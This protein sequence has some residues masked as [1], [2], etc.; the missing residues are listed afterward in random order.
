MENVVELKT[1][2]TQLGD[3][4]YSYI[5]GDVWMLGK[6]VAS[7]LEYQ[8]TDYA[9]RTHV[10][11]DNLLTRGIIG[12]TNDTRIKYAKFI[13]E[14]GF[15][16]LSMKSKKPNAVQLQ[17]WIANEVLPSLR[18]EG[19]Y[20]MNGQ[21]NQFFESITTLE[22][23]AIKGNDREHLDHMME[24]Y[25]K[26]AGISMNSAWKRFEG[27]YNR[28]YHTK[29]H[30]SKAAYEKKYNNGKKMSNPKYLEAVDKI[31][32][33]IAVV[34]QMIKERYAMPIQEDIAYD[35]IQHQRDMEF[36]RNLYV[37]QFINNLN[38]YVYSM[39]YRKSVAIKMGNIPCI[40]FADI[41]REYRNFINTEYPFVADLR[42]AYQYAW[43]NAFAIY[44]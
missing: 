26:M 24:T 19:H 21:S 27:C 2:S 20:D 16:Q 9:I 8:D 34:D 7:M 6:D 44:R 32:K 28:A 17:N 36:S 38:G 3:I 39:N 40:S 10:S 33:A 13:N 35:E 12:S 23:H 4:R 5:D 11:E 25:A 15:Y 22:E 18:K 31:N 1:K 37:E 29:I 14:A 41:P 42:S 43:D 30:V